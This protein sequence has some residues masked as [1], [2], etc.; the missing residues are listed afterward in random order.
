MAWHTK[1]RGGRDLSSPILVGDLVF[2]VNMGGTAN[3]YDAKAGKE[4]W[5]EKLG[6]KFSASPIVARG[7]IYVQGEAGETVVIEPGPALKIVA[8]NP[9]GA[10]GNEIFRSTMAASRG[11][12]LFRS[13]KAVY[14]VGK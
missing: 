13:D 12:L 7:F 11:R 5:N 2:V 8:R 10:P 3:V 4:L 14:C 9:L 1:R 6:G